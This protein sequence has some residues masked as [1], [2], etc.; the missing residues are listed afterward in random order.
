MSINQRIKEFLYEV[1]KHRAGGHAY[2]YNNKARVGSGED[3][4]RP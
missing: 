1:A 4:P 3:G 2:E